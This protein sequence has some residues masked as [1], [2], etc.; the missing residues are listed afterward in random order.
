MAL[1]LSGGPLLAQTQ[2]PAHADAPPTAGAGLAALQ[3]KTQV[4]N[5]EDLLDSNR[6]VVV[7]TLHLTLLTDG[8]VAATK[9]SGL[10]QAGNNSAKASATYRVTG[11]DKGFAQQLAQAAY[12]D[13]VG[14]MRQAGYT[15]LT[16]A[17][18]KERDFMKAAV[19]D[20]AV[21]PLGLPTK[22]EGSN[23]FVVA[24]PSDE[25]LFKSGFAGGDLAE[26]QSG[27]KSRFTDATLLFPQYTF[28]APQ[29]WAE[30][31]RGYKSVSAEAHVAHGMN[32]VSA[33]LTWMGQP[34]SRMMRGIPGVAT[35]EQVI[36]TTDKA[37]ELTQVADTTPQTANAVS[38]VLSLLGGG[39]IQKSSAEYQLAIDRDAFATGVL[40]GVRAFNAEVAKAAAAA[41]P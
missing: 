14:Q 29:A 27:G 17:D 5:P 30:G 15:V 23:Q 3:V 33:R 41:K 40:N 9:Q 18:I 1:T 2:A 20:T 25:Q 35:T 7:P 28:V 12:D 31:S 4:I 19:R 6:T 36:N 34:K 26:F 24:A 21:G 13:L 22:S 8:R 38:T 39:S 11:L 32:L 16:Y 37:G 10:F